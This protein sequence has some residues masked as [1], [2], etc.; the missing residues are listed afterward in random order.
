MTVKC[1]TPCSSNVRHRGLPRSWKSIVHLSSRFGGTA[2]T[3]RAV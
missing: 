2:A 1:P 3:A